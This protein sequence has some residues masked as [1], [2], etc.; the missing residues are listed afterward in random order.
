MKNLFIT[1]CSTILFL[2]FYNPTH[3]QAQNDKDQ[4][5]Y[6]AIHKIAPANYGSYSNSIKALIEGMHNAGV[7]NAEWHCGFQDDY[8]AIYAVPHDNFADLDK[9]YW[10]E[11]IE[12]MGKEKFQ[13]LADNLNAQIEKDNSALYKKKVA[14]GYKHASIDN[15]NTDYR[16][17]ITYEFK[18]GT[19]K[20]VEA[21]CKEWKD[22]YQK[23]DVKMQYSI[24]FGGIGTPDF[25]IIQV[26][27]GKDAGEVEKILEAADKKV[28]KEGEALWKRTK[29]LMVRREIKR[30]YYQRDL[31]FIPK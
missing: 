29:E 13:K 26:V 24:Y 18:P 15:S 23:H 5:Y 19:S 16:E 25:T 27:P 6:V 1:L 9:N 12:K 10:T 21:I 30:G 2:G 17:W 8:T 7:K 28:G 11:A 31:S 22:L 4:L 20:K 14:L 3:A